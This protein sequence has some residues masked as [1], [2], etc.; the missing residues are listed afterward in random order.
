MSKTKRKATPRPLNRQIS[1]Q[2]PP[3]LLKRLDVERRVYGLTRSTLIARAI[4]FY[5]ERT[6]QVDDAATATLRTDVLP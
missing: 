5:F 6:K 3:S 4:D 1:L 2:L